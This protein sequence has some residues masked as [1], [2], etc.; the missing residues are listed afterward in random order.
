MEEQLDKLPDPAL[1]KVGSPRSF[2]AELNNGSL[3]RSPTLATVGDR[4]KMVNNMDEMA[5]SSA[6]EV[7]LSL[8]FAQS[9]SAR[10]Q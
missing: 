1:P 9:R 10:L 6:S 7:I 5:S 4:C 2:G 3:T 8:A